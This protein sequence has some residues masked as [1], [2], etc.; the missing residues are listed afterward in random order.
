[1]FDTFGHLVYHSN[2]LYWTSHPLKAASLLAQKGRNRSHARTQDSHTGR[3]SGKFLQVIRARTVPF[4]M[5]EA[6]DA[7]VEILDSTPS[8]DLARAP[9]LSLI[10]NQPVLY[11]H[12]DTPA[13][14]I[15]IQ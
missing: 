3:S 9:G 8:A 15:S 12:Q 1:M 14:R 13:Y 6:V 5:K 10:L 2:R 7:T 11:Q 4:F